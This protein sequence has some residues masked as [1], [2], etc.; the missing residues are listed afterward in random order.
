MIGYREFIE[1]KRRTVQPFGFSPNMD[2]ISKRLFPWQ[3]DIVAWALKRGRAALFE[4]CGLGKTLQQLEWAAHVWAF[5]GRPVV[6]HCPVGVRA[7]TKAEAVKFEIAAPVEVVDDQSEVINGINLVNYEKLHKFDAA[8][9]SGVVLD[10]S[11]ILKSFTGSTKRALIDAYRETPYRLACTATPAPNDFMELG[12]HAEFLG[13]LDSND[14]LSRW[15]INDTMKAGG[16]R[17]RGHA[18]GDFW[19]WVS[20]WAVCLE[21]PSDIG[22]DNT[23]YDLPEMIEHE[24]MVDIPDEAPPGFLFNVGQLSATTMHHEKRRSAEARAKV[25]R[26]IIDKEPGEPWLIWCD[27]NYEADALIAAI[28]G[29]DVAEVRGSEKDSVKESKLLGFASGAYRVLITKPEI[30]GFGLNYQHCARVVFV[31]LSFSYERFYQAIR[32]TYRFGQTRAVHCHTIATPAENAMR[33]AV[34]EKQAKHIQMKTGMADAIRADQCREVLG[35][36]ERA[37][38]DAAHEIQIP[39]WLRRTQ[40]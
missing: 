27:T 24:H 4:D 33:R 7:Q 20:S 5:T 38:Y 37:R 39:T 6:I 36:L 16:Y 32:R 9:W 28:Q 34:M 3:R 22:G 23:G 13:V 19:R 14:M 29:D 18:V 21:K 15:F 8:Q 40:G 10:E 31:G 17:L 35:E 11:S 26:E 30:A 12:N 25:A 1:G 2:L